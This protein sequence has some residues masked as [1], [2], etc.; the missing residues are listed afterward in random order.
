MKRI[1]MINVYVGVGDSHAF[2]P[3]DEGMRKY[4]EFMQRHLVAVVRVSEKEVKKLRR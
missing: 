3:N 2:A 1:P 4:F